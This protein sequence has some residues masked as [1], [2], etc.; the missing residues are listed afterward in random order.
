MRFLATALS[1]SALCAVAVLSEPYIRQHQVPIA[2]RLREGSYSEYIYNLIYSGMAKGLYALLVI[3]LG[4]GELQRERATR[5]AGFTLS[6]PVSRL[7]V[8]GTQVAV[9]TVELAA[10]AS[11]PAILIPALSAFLHR[12]YPLPIALHFSVLWFFGG[13]IIFAASFL[14][15][16]VTPGEYTAPVACYLALVLHTF[17]AA[18]HPLAGY[19]LNLMWVMGEFQTMR[20]NVAHTL[21]LP[22][23]LSWLRM[24]VMA[25][26]ALLLLSAAIRVTNKQDY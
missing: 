9:G 10:L 14:L 25:C 19:R 6:L 15:S 1:L 3:F 7:R 20:W 16:V 13:M 18:W 26:F 21:L 23:P 22:P 2:L 24:C 8:V 4:L 5:T 17:V 11:V 12:S